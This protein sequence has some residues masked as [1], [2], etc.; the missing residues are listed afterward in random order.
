MATRNAWPDENAKGWKKL[1]CCVNT[2]ISEVSI[3][4]K[5]LLFKIKIEK[6]SLA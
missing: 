3:A 4:L 5:K 6:S 2:H 1:A